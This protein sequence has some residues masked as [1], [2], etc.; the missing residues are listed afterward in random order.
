VGKRTIA[1]WIRRSFK[2]PL[3]RTFLIIGPVAVLLLAAVY[4]LL[5]AFYL[6]A[7]SIGNSGL[8]LVATVISAIGTIASGAVAVLLYRNTLRGANITI[9]VEDLLYV[10]AQTLSRHESGEFW[11]QVILSFP[12]LFSNSGSRGGAI[13]GLDIAMITPSRTIPTIR[14][15]VPSTDKIDF[16]W[17]V[18]NLHHLSSPIKD[19]ETLAF[20][21]GLDLRLKEKDSKNNKPTNDFLKI[22]NRTPYFVFKFT[23][24]VTNARG[25]IVSRERLVKI[26]P[27]F[28]S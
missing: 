17:S 11:E 7:L 4:I 13:V 5:A 24:K 10:R 27:E 12:V 9:A 28:F 26:R 14:D 18:G 8:E 3:I 25:K 21:A 20:T 1:D 16:Y 2:E 6:L 15:G 22:Q 19:S 23:Y